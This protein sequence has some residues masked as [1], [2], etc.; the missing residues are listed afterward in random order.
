MLAIRLMQD[1]GIAV[2]AVNFKTLFSCCQ[3]TAGRAAQDL[4]V[5][6][7]VLGAEDD[8]L[9]LVKSPRFGYGKGANPCVDC[10]IY[11]FQRAY[12]FMEQVGADFIV[13]GEVIGQR[14]MSQKRRDLETISH[15]SALDDLLLRPLSARLLPPTLP[16][17]EGW[18]DRERLFDFCGRS[19]KGLIALA[20]K[21]HFNNIPSPSTGCALTEP[22]FARKV[23][24]LIQLDPAAGMWD[25]D[26]LK[27]GR[28]FRLNGNTKVVVGRQ[29]SENDQLEY[30]HDLP[31]ASSTAVLTPL[32]FQGPLSLVVGPATPAALDFSGGLVLRYSKFTTDQQPSVMV[33]TRHQHFPIKPTITPRVSQART[34]AASS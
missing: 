1:Q 3:E 31:Q 14:P 8:Y 24:D 34:L 17:R 20:R 5:R 10:R 30:L 27:L 18:V 11:M 19:R 13:S 9:E 26:L 7:T 12:R 15:H 28:H 2:E 25:Y 32:N 6:I 4:G 23:T 29:K 33:R 16:E 22:Q 21:F